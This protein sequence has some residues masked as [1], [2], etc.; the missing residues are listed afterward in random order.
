VGF[1]E[2]LLP[3][4][5]LRGAHPPERLPLLYVRERLLAERG[6]LHRRDLG[7]RLLAQAIQLPLAGALPLPRR[8][9]RR[10]QGEIAPQQL[11]R[12]RPVLGREGLLRLPLE[13]ARFA[14]PLD[15]PA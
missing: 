8:P 4:L 14:G 2:E 15:R 10:P 12:P 9:V 5:R 11:V 1:R 6:G 7:L 3:L 13:L